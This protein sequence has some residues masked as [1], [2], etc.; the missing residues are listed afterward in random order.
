MIYSSCYL[1]HIHAGCSCKL[2]HIMINEMDFFFF[3]SFCPFG[4]CDLCIPAFG[5]A[6]LRNRPIFKVSVCDWLLWW[7]RFLILPHCR[8]ISNAQNRITSTGNLPK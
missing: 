2:V 7:Y 5:I 8:L 3:F 4:S 6:E 1:V